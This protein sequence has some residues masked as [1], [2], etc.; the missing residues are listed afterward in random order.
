MGQLARGDAC[1]E[2]Y[3]E[4]Q[5]DS[6]RRVVRGRVHFVSGDRHRESGWIFL[7]WSDRD[8]RERFNEFSATELWSLLEALGP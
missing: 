7:E 4:V 3:L 8:L 1:W 5:P 2:V 6:E